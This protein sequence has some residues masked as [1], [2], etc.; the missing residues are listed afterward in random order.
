VP[1]EHMPGQTIVDQ[2]RLAF[3][4]SW[5]RLNR[6]VDQI[7]L[8]WQWLYGELRFSLGCLS[9]RERATIRIDGGWEEDGRLQI[10][11]ET[12]DRVVQGVLRKARVRAMSTCMEC[13]RPGKL[14][15]LDEWREATLCGTCA[16]PRLLEFEIARIIGLAGCGS[17]DLGEEL[18]SSPHAVLV[19]AAAEAA[20][21]SRNLPATSVL[22]D[23]DRDGQHAWLQRLRDRAQLECEV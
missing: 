11:S 7:P 8:G 3:A 20:A 15:Q 1:T 16:G 21:A 23:L 10:Q 19:R 4:N 6:L 9:S 5:R 22:T 14:R 13:G 18:Q 17:V 12:S 2:D